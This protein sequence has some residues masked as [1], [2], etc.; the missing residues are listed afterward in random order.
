MKLAVSLFS[1]LL[2][3]VLASVALT[4]TVDASGESPFAG[5]E[6]VAAAAEEESAEKSDA[7]KPSKE[8]LAAKRRSIDRKIAVA[9]LKLE[10]AKMEAESKQVAAQ[11]AIHQAEEE[12]GLARAKLVQYRDVDAPN[13]IEQARLSLQGAKDRAQEAQEELRQIE[14]MYEDQDLDDRTAEFVVNRG[15]RQAE[16][17][18]RQ[19]AIQ[20]RSLSSL[21]EH[22]VPRELRRLQL[23][24]DRKEAALEKARR[25][26]RSGEVQRKISLMSAEMELANLRDEMKKLEDQEKES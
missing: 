5:Q 4:L 26:A 21:T 10:H 8:D 17:A 12:L 2:L 11:E 1:L 19:I 13:K 20:E 25:D 3:A 14:I 16:R 18:A 15:R 7:K 6:A 24:L 23:D 9:E 22:E